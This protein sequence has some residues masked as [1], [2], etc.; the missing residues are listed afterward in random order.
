MLTL[1]THDTA[2]SETMRTL[3]FGQNEHDV[4]CP[5][6]DYLHTA[7]NASLVRAAAKRHGDRYAD[8]IRKEDG[9]PPGGGRPN[10]GA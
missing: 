6:W 7:Q 10:R 3:V 8:T 2:T 5:A 4:Y 9:K 1:A